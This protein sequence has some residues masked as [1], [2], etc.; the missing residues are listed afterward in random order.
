ME[1][2]RE[3]KTRLSSEVRAERTRGKGHKLQQGEFQE[4]MNEHLFEHQTG[5]ALGH[6]IP[7][8]GDFQH[9][10]DEN[11]KLHVLTWK[12]FLLGIESSRDPFQPKRFYNSVFPTTLP[13][14]GKIGSSKITSP[15][16]AETT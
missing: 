8:L 16:Q 3:D 15:C 13:S 6:L 14:R 5:A 9:S 12:W 2:Y 10:A 11:L 7:V 1:G 4:D